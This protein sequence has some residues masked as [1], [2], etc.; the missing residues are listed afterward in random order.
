MV[1]LLMFLFTY[2]RFIHDY[3]GFDGCLLD[4]KTKLKGRTKWSFSNILDNHLPWLATSSP[5]LMKFLQA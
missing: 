5:R 2:G 1:D 3:V 4:P